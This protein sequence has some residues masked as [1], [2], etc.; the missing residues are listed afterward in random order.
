[1]PVQTKRL[2]KHP[3]QDAIQVPAH[4][5]SA[6]SLFPVDPIFKAYIRLIGIVTNKVNVGVLQ[7]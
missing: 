2:Q 6:A 7:I 1:M 5:R 3:R 4:P